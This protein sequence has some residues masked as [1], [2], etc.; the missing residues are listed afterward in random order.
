MPNNYLLVVEGAKDEKNIL[1]SVLVVFTKRLLNF[2]YVAQQ[3]F[4]I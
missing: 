2:A 1:Q 3:F 4:V